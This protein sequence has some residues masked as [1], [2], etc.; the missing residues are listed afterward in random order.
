MN[1]INLTFLPGLLLALALLWPAA[2]P[3]QAR[4]A[5]FQTASATRTTT[6][7]PS[8]A[9][10][11]TPTLT[12]T[13]TTGPTATLTPIPTQYLETPDQTTGILFGAVFLLVI[14]LGGTLFT[15]RSRR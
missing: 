10:T 12:Q 13:P 8:P 4:A 3:A 9:L 11:P 5:A 6:P 1:K 2:V 7:S 15:I 14:I